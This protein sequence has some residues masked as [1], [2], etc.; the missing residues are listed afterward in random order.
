VVASGRAGLVLRIRP[1]GR[2]KKKCYK[3]GLQS[4]QLISAVNIMMLS[5]NSSVQISQETVDNYK[6]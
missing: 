4:I 6:K 1:Q 3:Y 5:K 2:K